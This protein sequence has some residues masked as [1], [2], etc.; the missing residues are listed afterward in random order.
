MRV[1]TE[2]LHRGMALI[3]DGLLHLLYPQYCVGCGVLVHETGLPLCPACTG[4]LERVAPEDLQARFSRLPEAN[5]L[6]QGFA[7]WHFDKGGTLQHLQHA[8]K[9]G[10]RPRYGL[11]LG[12]LLGQAYQ[13]A[14]QPLPDLVVPI[15]L[16]A[17]R[18]YERGYNQSALLAEGL[19]LTLG[20]PLRNDSL[21]RRQATRSQAEL[22]RRARWE[23]VRAAFE[24]SNPATVAAR[25]I[26]LVDDVVTTGATAA[27]AARPLLE[28]GATHI[29]L[30]ALALARGQ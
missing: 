14:G 25:S 18:R 5:V 10:N 2:K 9:Y 28:A 23:N 8:L 3:R 4:L 26:L 7:L 16:H 29:D 24:A 27:A 13:K 11:H 21:V 22:S 17:S 15:P 6:R 30:A 1:G 19:A 12:A 20:R